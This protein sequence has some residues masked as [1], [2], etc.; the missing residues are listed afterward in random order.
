MWTFTRIVHIELPFMLKG[1]D[2][3]HNEGLAKF[4]S[5]LFY[6]L[7]LKHDIIPF[8]NSGTVYIYSVEMDT[9]ALIQSL[10]INWSCAICFHEIS[11]SL[12]NY[13]FGRVSTQKGWWLG[14]SFKAF[15]AIRSQSETHC[16]MSI[17]EWGPFSYYYLKP[18]FSFKEGQ[19]IRIMIVLNFT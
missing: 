6:P 7:W 12:E 3:I 5:N 1:T 10:I 14:I 9:T 17:Y 18:R 8:F 13:F 2:K 19:N 11:L 16:M 4:P 15:F